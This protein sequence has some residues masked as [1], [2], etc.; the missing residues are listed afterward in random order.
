MLS[1]EQSIYHYF[2]YGFHNV[3]RK[4]SKEPVQTIRSPSRTSA[5]IERSALQAVKIWDWFLLRSRPI[6]GSFQ[7]LCRHPRLSA[8]LFLPQFYFFY[9]RRR[10]SLRLS[11]TNAVFSFV[12]TGKETVMSLLDKIMKKSD[13]L[14]LVSFIDVHQEG[15]FHILGGKVLTRY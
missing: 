13:K 14:N 6:G 11:R 9:E 10:S 2:E 7:S 3:I 1:K 15:F 8:I 5:T 4:F 12:K